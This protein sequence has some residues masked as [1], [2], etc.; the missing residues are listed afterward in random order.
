MKLEKDSNLYSAS[1][2]GD[3]DIETIE[4]TFPVDPAFNWEP[5]GREK[6]FSGVFGDATGIVTL[7]SGRRISVTGEVRATIG[8]QASNASN[9]KVFEKSSPTP[10]LPTMFDQWG[11]AFYYRALPD[12]A[13]KDYPLLKGV[14]ITNHRVA[15]DATG[16]MSGV[17][18]AIGS[19]GVSSN[20]AAKSQ[21]E[22]HYEGAGGGN[23]GGGTFTLRTTNFTDL[24]TLT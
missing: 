10:L 15:P 5:T 17:A 7:K 6:E 24:V 14:T 1:W 16:G 4:Y 11:F 12:R 2:P 21:A 22:Y 23:T 9:P 8:G 18:E 13:L 20:H 19:S 3:L